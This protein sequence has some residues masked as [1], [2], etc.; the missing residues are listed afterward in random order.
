MATVLNTTF[1]EV[2][3][4]GAQVKFC[5]AAA[6]VR[7]GALTKPASTQLDA[8][9]MHECQ[10]MGEQQIGRAS[11]MIDHL[12]GLKCTCGTKQG[13]GLASLSLDTKPRGSAIHLEQMHDMPMPTPGCVSFFGCEVR[14]ACQRHQHC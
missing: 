13:L 10:Y 4:T 11:R 2:T 7:F 9:D 8:S 1:T 14:L 5:A 12:C 3:D 6:A